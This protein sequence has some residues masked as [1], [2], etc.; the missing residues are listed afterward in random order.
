MKEFTGWEKEILYH[1]LS[2]L[3]DDS[4]LSQREFNEIDNLRDRFYQGNEMPTY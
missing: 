3:L 2:R 4:K 1:A